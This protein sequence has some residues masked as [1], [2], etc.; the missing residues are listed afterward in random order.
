MS[1]T[2]S[3]NDPMNENDD[4]LA[5]ALGRLPREKAPPGALEDA[6]VSRL[7]SAGL[8]KA[9]P[10]ART[11]GGLSLATWV[12]AASIAAIT[13]VGGS[14]YRNSRPQP[15][16]PLFALTVYTAASTDD[17]VTSARKSDEIDR[18]ALSV[19][20]T[21]RGAARPAVDFDSDS[22]IVEEEPY[23]NKQIVRTY[24][25]AVPSKDSAVSVAKN[26][27]WVKYGARVVVRSVLETV[28]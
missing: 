19:N 15:S 13:F 21:E 5:G 12:L 11:S 9:A 28:P 14:V 26:C 7:R 17:S 3:T 20:A 25:I 18:W 10:L 6:T 4:I 2:D 23:R 16:E 8:L 1:M 24:Y 27:P 22:I